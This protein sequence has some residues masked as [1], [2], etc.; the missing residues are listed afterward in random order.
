M[1]ANSTSPQQVSNA[2]GHVVADGSSN[3]SSSGVVPPYF[4]PETLVTSILKIPGKVSQG[5]HVCTCCLVGT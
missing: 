5:S 2:A 1:A 3:S 4:P